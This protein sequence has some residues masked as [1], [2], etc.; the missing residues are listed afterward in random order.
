MAILKKCSWS[1]CTKIVKDNIKYCEYH[2]KKHSTREK[3]RYKEYNIHKGMVG[4]ICDAEIRD[5]CFH[6]AF[7]DE[8]VKDKDFMSVEENIY[9]LKEDIFCSIRI[10]DLELVEDMKTSDDWILDSIPK[11]NKKW[12]CKVEDGYIVNLQGEKLNK[13]PY[14]YNS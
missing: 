6:V 10:E 13:V 12:W 2:S 8:R 5:K 11:H 3:E 14:D 9:K 7:I 4:T 1:S